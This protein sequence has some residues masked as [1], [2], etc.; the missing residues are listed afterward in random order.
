MFALSSLR[1]TVI[2]MVLVI[3]LPLFCAFF[4]KAFGGFRRLDNA[5]PREFL[6]STHGLASRLNHA[7]TNSFEGLAIFIGAVLMALYAFVPISVINQLALVYLGSRLLFIIS[8]AFNWA[9][10]RS[11]SW[12]IGLMSCLMMFFFAFYVSN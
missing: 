8:Y 9:T 1:L 10:F 5:T 4:A 7:Q 6:A 12:V 11:V 2:L 3:F